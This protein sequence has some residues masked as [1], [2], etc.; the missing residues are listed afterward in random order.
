MAGMTE[1][2]GGGAGGDEIDMAALLEGMKNHGISLPNSRPATAR[3]TEPPVVQQEPTPAPVADAPPAEPTPAVV[4]EEQQPVQS[5]PPKLG[6]ARSGFGFSALRNTLLEDGA[7]APP[8][9]VPT[10]LLEVQP[11]LA[12][13]PIAERETEAVSPA[14]PAAEAAAAP[15]EKPTVSKVVS[16]TIDIIDANPGGDGEKCAKVT[17][18]LLYNYSNETKEY[19]YTFDNIKLHDFQ[20]SEMKTRFHPYV[21]LKCDAVGWNAK[22][23]V[24]NDAGPIVNWKLSEAERKL[25]AKEALHNNASGLN[26][27]VLIKKNSVKGH[28]DFLIGLGELP[29]QSVE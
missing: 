12:L 27:K 16:K 21:E 24:E 2:A 6:E 29:L 3:V 25:V 23:E 7:E 22:T 14:P 5:Q 4:A 28:E 8:S 10:P 1:E 13:E 9:R 20:Q 11:E 15:V 17:F 18:D 26:V 19:N